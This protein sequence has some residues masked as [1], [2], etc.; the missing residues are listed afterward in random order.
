GAHRRGVPPRRRRWQ[1]RGTGMDIDMATLRMVER[2][3]DIPLQTLVGAIE[4]AL[5][6][7]YH[8][9]PGAFRHA[10]VELDQ[11]T[12]HGGLYA[13]EVLPAVQEPAIGE[14][15]DSP[16]A[17]VKGPADGAAG[18]STVPE[19]TEP[20]STAAQNAAAGSTP[21][22]SGEAP[23]AQETGATAAVAEPTERLS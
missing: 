18:E 21:A 23:G 3:R 7:A 2:E 5:L 15:A 8:R 13:R 19:T 12:G 11:R 16:A 17:P 4:Q 1:V 14:A 20:G 9:T 10:R 6:S 22:E